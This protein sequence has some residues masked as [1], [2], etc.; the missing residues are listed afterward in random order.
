MYSTTG[1]WYHVSIGRGVVQLVKLLDQETYLGYPGKDTLG[2]TLEEYKYKPQRHSL[3]IQ[4]QTLHSLRLTFPFITLR[5]P[6]PLQITAMYQ[7]MMLL[8][9]LSLA[10]T[11][12]SM[13]TTPNNQRDTAALQKR[14]VTNLPTNLITCRT[15]THIGD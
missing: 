11:A 7:P 4:H 14:T 2:R 5:F 10:Q 1:G 9:G 13:P 8:A 6:Q 3:L 12:F 15:S